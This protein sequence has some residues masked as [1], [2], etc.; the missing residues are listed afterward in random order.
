MMR[1]PFLPS[2][3][4][5]TS[6]AAAGPTYGFDLLVAPGVTS[7]GGI[8]AN[9]GLSFDWDRRWFESES[10]HLSG[11]WNLGYTWWER[12]KLADSEHSVSF[13][14]VFVYQF[15]SESWRPFVEFGIGAAAF[16]ASRVGDRHLG[17]KLHFEDRLGVGIRPGDGHALTLRAIH[18]SNASVKEPNDGIESWSLVYTRRF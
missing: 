15:R 18:Y 16:S 8:T 2:L 7:Q 5:I 12:G 4:V 11:Y 6:L 17:S 9:I 1:K 10:G 14:P 13:S 3:L